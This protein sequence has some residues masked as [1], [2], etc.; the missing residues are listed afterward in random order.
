MD[1]F[2]DNFDQPEVDPAAEFL[3]REQDQLAGLEDEL[4]PGNAPP[5]AD[6]AMFGTQ[7]SAPLTGSFEMIDNFGQQDGLGPDLLSSAPE[8][9]PSEVKAESEPLDAES[10]ETEAENSGS[11][12]AAA[13][14]LDVDNYAGGGDD[15][16]TCDDGETAATDRGAVV[17]C[18]GSV[19]AAE[20]FASVIDSTVDDDS[21]ASDAKVQLDGLTSQPKI[22]STP[23]PPKPVVKEEPE[24]I[25]KWRE[26]QKKRLEEKDANEEKRKEELREQAKKEL[27][28]WY[29]H[30]EEQIAKTKAA[31]RNAEK[32]FVA[33]AGEIEPGTEW[34]RIAKLCDFNPKSSKTS[35]DVSRM[36]S[37]ILQ[38]KQTPPAA[39]RA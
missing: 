2:G 1:G 21:V 25:R 29:K 19:A 34:E 14:V 32:Q 24:K 17:E 13:A 9:V 11:E 38:L 37:I 26:E 27:E 28:E 10:K 18:D 30:H 4:N 23:T 36:R 15:S 16:A 31:N 6:D 20:G 7:G 39:K 5:A 33:E 3:A 35:K 22:F 12:D 8:G